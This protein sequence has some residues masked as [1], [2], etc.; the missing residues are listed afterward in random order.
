MPFSDSIFLVGGNIQF[1]PIILQAKN[2]EERLVRIESRE[3][4]K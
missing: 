2:I 4:N 1:L 3:G